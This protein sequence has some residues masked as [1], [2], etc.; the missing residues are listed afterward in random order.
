M[1]W[2]KAQIFRPA[3]LFYK[4]E[5]L[6]KGKIV[7]SH[8]PKRLEGTHSRKGA[9]N[10][11]TWEEWQ[12]KSK[13][14]LAAAQI[15]LQYDKPVEAASRAY[16]A[17]YQMVTAVLI[18]FKLSPRSEYGNWAHHETQDMYLTHICQK[19][20]LEYK[21]KTALTMLR[22][23]FWNLL[24]RRYQA[25]YGPD[26]GIDMFLARSILRDANKL[27]KLLENLIKRGVL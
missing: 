1:G 5:R 25:D 6:R 13:S 23:A 2:N 7:L 27:V 15:L 21:E 14:S 19:A 9:I 18:K 11:L 16:Y 12:A 3:P 20:D 26:K 4:A 10:V 22:P 17:A 24:L 8:L